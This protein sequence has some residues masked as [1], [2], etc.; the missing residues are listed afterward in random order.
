MTFKKKARQHLVSLMIFVLVMILAMVVNYF[1]IH[2]P[3]MTAYLSAFKIGC[4]EAGET[5]AVCSA[6]ASSYVTNR[7]GWKFLFW[8]EEVR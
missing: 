4:L 1:A 7:F 8:R 6:R 3:L 2:R 5:S